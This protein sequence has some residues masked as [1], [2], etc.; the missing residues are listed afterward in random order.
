MHSPLSHLCSSRGIQGPPP[1][2][3]PNSVSV[4]PSA[5]SATAA[6]PQPARIHTLLP[7]APQ[8]TAL[9]KQALINSLHM[10]CNAITMLTPASGRDSE[11][12]ASFAVACDDATAAAHGNFADVVRACEWGGA[13]FYSG[14]CVNAYESRAQP[15][16]NGC[17]V[18]GTCCLC[19]PVP[20]NGF[21]LVFANAS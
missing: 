1:S 12:T 21:S 19:A 13:N 16:Q 7:I 15:L 6:L 18:R 9:V 11:P 17:S 5:A 4:A 2:P 10:N 14:A 20:A 3:P 8:I